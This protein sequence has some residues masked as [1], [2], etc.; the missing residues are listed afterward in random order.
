LFI[1]CS[2]RSAPGAHIV[3]PGA[4]ESLRCL[5]RLAPPGVGRG[6][7][8]GVREGPGYRPRLPGMLL[9]EMP[10]GRPRGEIL[11]L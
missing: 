10:P 9:T 1:G 6:Q 4:T 11:G 5:R 8:L 3:A 2:F 7:N